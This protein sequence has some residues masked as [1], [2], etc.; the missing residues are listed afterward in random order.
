MLLAYGAN[1]KSSLNVLYR[2]LNLAFILLHLSHILLRICCICSQLKLLLRL[3]TLI[4][5]LGFKATFRNF[6]ALSL[7]L[8]FLLGGRQSARLKA[9]TLSK[10]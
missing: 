4:V 10:T 2:F 9:H 3:L 6:V 7:R 5:W 1:R 8:N